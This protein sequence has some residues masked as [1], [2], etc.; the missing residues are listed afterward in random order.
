MLILLQI[1][2]VFP[3]SHNDPYS[4]GC[5][6]VDPELLGD[7]FDIAVI[8]IIAKQKIIK[9]ISHPPVLHF[10]FQDD[11][12]HTLGNIHKRSSLP[13]DVKQ[14]KLQFIGFVDHLLRDGF[15]IIGDRNPKAGNPKPI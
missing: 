15:F 1:D 2:A 12:P 14:R 9:I 5:C 6:K 7:F 11:L 8:N 3:V 10:I 4:A 13:P